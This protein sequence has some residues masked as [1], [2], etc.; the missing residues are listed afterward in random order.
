MDLEEYL[1]NI[2]EVEPEESKK[3]YGWLCD[4]DEGR[5]LNGLFINAKTPQG[6]IL[7]LYRCLKKHQ[8]RNYKGERINSLI[9]LLEIPSGTIC[10][11]TEI[12]NIC[13]KWVEINS[14]SFKQLIILDESD[15]C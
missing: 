11:L 5:Q 12:N 4:P 3:Y 10:D 15:T 7:K 8:E 6:A 9:D 2:E 14:I 13:E 1:D